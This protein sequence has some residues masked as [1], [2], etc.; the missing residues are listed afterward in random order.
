MVSFARTGGLGLRFVRLLVVCVTTASARRDHAFAVMKAF[1]S[2]SRS[3]HALK[4]KLRK[5]LRP[6]EDSFGL[7]I[8]DDQGILPGEEW[9][10]RIW[11]EF[12]SSQIIILIVTENFLSSEFCL[13]E[14]VCSRH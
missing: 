6:I 3:D 13:K 8:F 9:E 4:A 11:K 10:D 14:R 2:Y 1:I 5:F 12:D 7:S